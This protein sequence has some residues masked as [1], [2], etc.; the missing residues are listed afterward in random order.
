MACVLL[1]GLTLSGTSSAYGAPGFDPASPDARVGDGDRYATAALIAEQNWTSADT[2]LVAN[3]E[4]N[5][6]DA[7]S[8]SYLAGKRNA[9]ILL[10]KAD[11]VPAETAAAIRRLDPQEVI[12]LGAEPSVS[13]ATFAELTAGR[14]A[15]R[16]GGSDRY[17]TA[18]DI[19]S[20]GLDTTPAGLFALPKGTAPRSAFI[21]RGDLYDDDV[22]ADALAASPVAY[23]GGVPVLLTGRNSLPDATV[24]ALAGLGTTTVYVL[25]SPN[26]V[27]EDV[28]AQVRAAT[29]GGAVSRIQGADRTQTAAA[30]AESQVA[31]DAGFGR[32]TVGIANG[33]RVDALAAGPAAGRAGYPLLLTE[34]ADTLGAGTQAYLRAHAA[35]LTGAKVFGNAD[36]V[37]PTATQTARNSGGGSS[38]PAPP[39]TPVP[40]PPDPTPEEPQETPDPVVPAPTAVGSVALTDDPGGSLVVLTLSEALPAERTLRV[41]RRTGGGGWETV[42]DVAVDPDDATV[43]RAPRPTNP[44]R[45]SYRASVSD[46]TRYSPTTTAAPD[47][48]LSPAAPTTVTAV[49]EASAGT[50]K[51]TLGSALTAGQT[52]EVSYR[53]TGA[54]TWTLL[55]DPAEA[56]SSTVYRV[57]R[58]SAA[59][60]YVFQV[61]VLENG[62][63]SAPRAA[64]AV[65]IPP[66]AL[67]FTATDDLA[68]GRVSLTLSRAV[69]T[70][71][72]LRIDQKLGSVT[73]QISAEVVEWLDDTHLMVPRPPVGNASY[74]L[75]LTEAGL[76][77]KSTSVAVVVRPTGPASVD[78][79][80]NP[81]AKEVVLTLGTAPAAGQTLKIEQKERDSV[82]WSVAQTDS[83]PSSPNTEVVRHLVRP[84]TAG[85]YVYRATFT[86]NSAPS[87][88]TQATGEVA[89]PPVVTV[90]DV[91]AQQTVNL[92]LAVAATANQRVVVEQ[93][94]STDGTWTRLPDPVR[95]GVNTKLYRV[96]RP[97][98]PEKY[99]YRV[100]L[101]RDGLVTAWAS[102]SK[103]VSVAHPPFG[104]VTATSVANTVTLTFDR[105]VPAG[106]TVSVGYLRGSSTSTTPTA[107]TTA[108]LSGDRLSVTFPRPTTPDVYT[109]RASIA[110]FGATSPA[111]VAGQTVTVRPTAPTS[112]TVVDNAAGQTVALTLPTAPA[113]G[114]TVVIEVRR[115]GDEEW[116]PVLN[117]TVTNT[118]RTY[119]VARP[120]TVGS[121]QY[122]VTFTQNSVSSNPTAGNVSIT[123]S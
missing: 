4:T 23:R 19:V 107:V 89:I 84:T 114:R 11:S 67:S 41:E 16:I 53:L 6:I 78:V 121:Y 47:L 86:Q 3:G 119:T 55:P 106:A 63:P 115:A 52:L 97:S 80:D 39:R 103:T 20:A 71:Q 92:T 72:T 101:E 112:V 54:Q 105:A 15:R 61:S 30:I 117:P 116:T 73:S 26:A 104:T 70:G 85:F 51:L 17:A 66:S 31:V 37:S 83:T 21:A 28:A 95:D 79:L 9:P 96:P 25:G 113:T 98:S 94:T 34:S 111:T 24:S 29:G 65:S 10:T 69:V 87:A 81:S 18:A 118:Q 42:D 59:G 99:A 2:V 110:Q 74:Q 44:G 48:L 13:A 27:S 32:T 50:V 62:A 88:P 38:T 76:T 122:R 14:T 12:V 91:A 8:A 120:A 33:Y 45:Y 77:T 1:V 75:A 108:V 46:G 57:P 35:T 60:A 5:G 100:R 22:P 123:V 58:P 7:L 93:Q 68:G 90:T 109:Y 102:G 49:N 40:Q 64:N 82:T 36:A 56:V 43:Y